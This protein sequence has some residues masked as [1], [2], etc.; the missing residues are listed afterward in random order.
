MHISDM[1]LLSS[2]KGYPKRLTIGF[3][4]VALMASIVSTLLLID[5]FRSYRAEIDMLVLSKSVQGAVETEAARDTLMLLL[6]TAEFP[7]TVNETTDVVRIE[8]LSTGKTSFRISVISDTPV[9]ARD[10]AIEVSREL[11]SSV[12]RY[13]DIRNNITVRSIGAPKVGG[14]IMYPVVLIVSGIASGIL[15]TGAFFF[16]VLSLARM[17]FSFRKEEDMPVSEQVFFPKPRNENV[18]HESEEAPYV[19]S[20]DAF[21]PKKVDAKFFSFE[22]SGIEREK[23]Y[24]H[25]NR[26]PAPMNLPVALDESEAIPEFVSLEDLSEGSTIELDT[27]EGL[28]PE[29]EPMIADTPIEALSIDREPTAEEYKKRL[30]D[31]LKGKMPR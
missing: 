28:F 13:Y 31:L 24:A 5:H 20:S 1:S 10:G 22:P 3:I 7:S 2:H 29:I 6:S 16:I 19:F 30:N 27:N 12:G 15:F 11:F 23:D 4:S 9:D 8:S 14:F 21:V 18:S 17:A 26:G 25:F